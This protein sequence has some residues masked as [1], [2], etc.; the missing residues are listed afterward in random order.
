MGPLETEYLSKIPKGL[1]LNVRH[2]ES[3]L[4]TYDSYNIFQKQASFKGS[5]LDK[6][7]LEGSRKPLPKLIS[8]G[9]PESIFLERR[10]SNDQQK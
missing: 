2:Q 8:R 5:C 1:F 3:V 7:L 6:R 4:E 9:S 10:H